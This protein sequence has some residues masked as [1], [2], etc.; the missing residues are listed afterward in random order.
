M[1]FSRPASQ[2]KGALQHDPALARRVGVKRVLARGVLLAERILPLFLPILGIAALFVSLAWFGVF[3]ELPEILRL[4][5]VFLLIFAFVASFLPFLRLTMPT[6]READRLLEK[7]NGLPHQPVAVQDDALAADTPFARAL[8][9]EHQRRMAERIAAL[10]AGLPQPDI[11]RYDRHALR[12]VPA[13]LFVTALAYSGSN[14]AGTIADAFR[15]H[16]A[17]TEQPAIRIDAWITP[18]AYTGQPPVF[19][20][21]LGTQ[22]SGIVVPQN[23][24]MTVRISGG[25]TDEKVLFVKQGD[26]TV[27]EVAAS[28]PKAAAN[29]ATPAPTALPPAAP[30]AASA[31][32][33]VSTA[34]QVART[35][36]LD[37]A[38]AGQLRV[39]DRQ[40]TIGVT[41][42]KAP[43]IAFDGKPRRA[44]N[45][46]LEIAFTAKDDYGLQKAHAE[47]VPVEEKTDAKPLYPLPDYKL[48]LPRHNA[49]DMKSVASRN[50][51]EHPLAGSKVKITLVATDGA[52]QTGRSEPVE[53]VL[54]TRNFAEPLAAAVAE[55]RQTFALDTREM[56]QAIAL[57]EALVIRADETI[58]NLG[59]F[60]LIESA[61]ARMAQAKGEEA[62]KDTA[63]YLWEIALGIEDGELSTAEKRLRDAQQA[64]AD[65]LEN[66]ATDREIKKLMDELR[67][68]MND[69]ISEL[70]Q[71]MPN[72][73]GEQQQ[74]AQNTLRQK[75]LQN[76]L[77][78]LENLAR[79]GNRDQAQQLLS[80]LQR[81]MN[82]LQAGRPQQGQQ[83][84]NSEARRQIDKLGEIM[85]QQ[86]QLMDE[87][88]R[89]DQALRDRMQRGDPQQ[90]EE[91]AEGEQQDLG[92]QGQQGQQ[93]E[94][95][96]QGGQPNLDGMTAD[97]LREALRQLRQQQE[98]L[99]KQLG[100]LQEGLKGLGMKPGKGFGQAQQEMEGAGEALGKSQGDRAVQGQGR[101]MEA[102]R[103]GARDMMNQMM[104]AMRGQQGQGQEMG[105]GRG[106]QN[107][108]DP[109]GRPRAT[110]GPDF[111]ERVKVPDE[112]DVQRAREILEAIREKL[113]QNSSPEIERRYLERLL[114]IQ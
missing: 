55:Q 43:E 78:Q 88:F 42:D 68:A 22:T 83:Q 2:R 110:N 38:E 57:S 61:R 94:Q 91:G 80:E 53:M 11:A 64:L 100:E 85:Q 105:Q 31:P 8:W 59:H 23:S 112:I 27:V 56:P 26:G 41:P 104:Q 48:D 6:A 13:L 51:T 77:D 35:H 63:D 32:A 93:G 102:L 76:L 45:G 65:A 114:D 33:G 44:L 60:L 86:Q 16:V 7:R 54:P 62:L 19:L 34:P 21:G 79:S 15:R 108:R 99:G 10:D 74:N 36:E 84:E 1:I 4:G 90:G 96:K 87:T 47:I 52:G 39:A 95:G 97:Q 73:S 30:Q 20:S 28:D 9:Q 40:W 106:N 111:G 5:L 18:P 98:G 103:Q 109:L 3:R 14:G 82:N 101:A 58:P 12:A 107:D 66:G 24:K 69:F 67:A 72:Q 81:M 50:I 49:R 17:V 46:A 37:L 70:A 71:R 25:A 89:L 75:D 113:G 92:Q 29:G